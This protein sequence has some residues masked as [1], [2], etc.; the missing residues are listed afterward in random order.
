MWSRVFRCVCVEW[1][2]SG[3]L[4]RLCVPFLGRGLVGCIVGAFVFLVFLDTSAPVGGVFSSLGGFACSRV[5]V[6][7]SCPLSAGE[8]RK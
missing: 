3:P 2:V 8:D 6:A 7:A 4:W 1:Q 5:L